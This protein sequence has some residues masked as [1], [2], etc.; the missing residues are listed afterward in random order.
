M[1]Y[2]AKSG[3]V[4]IKMDTKQ[5]ER[6]SFDNGTTI[7]IEKGFD[8]NLRQDKAS[9]AEVID[10]ENIPSG[11]ECLIHHNSQEP[12]Y[13]VFNQD[14]LT[15]KE[16]LDGFKILSIPE[17]MCFC[18]YE[19]GEWEPCKNF[20][21][22]KRI[23]KPYN[24]PLVGIEPE[25]IKN[26]MYVVKGL[27]G[28]DEEKVDLSGKVLVTLVNCDYQIIW[29][30]KNNREQTLIRTRHREILAIDNQITE[31]VNQGVLNVGVS[32]AE[33]KPIVSCQKV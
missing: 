18:Y 25:L 32:P 30:D 19:N 5:K 22:T 12:S 3:N 8:F 17:D 2:K 11:V 21:I 7:H 13:E 6:Y 33:S 4:L 24:G 27:D 14:I 10:A 31:M 26:R 23:F 20:L 28:W 15:Q 16:K 29:N 1:N 9:M